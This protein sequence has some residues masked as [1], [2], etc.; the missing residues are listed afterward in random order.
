MA[1]TAKQVIKARTASHSDVAT[2]DPARAYQMAV[3]ERQFGDTLVRRLRETKGEVQLR[4]FQEEWVSIDDG[5][6]YEMSVEAVVTE[7]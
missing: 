7:A 3:T 6:V 4:N 5:L 1:E 2:S